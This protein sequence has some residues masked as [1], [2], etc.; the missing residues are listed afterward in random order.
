METDDAGEDFIRFSYADVMEP[1]AGAN[2]QLREANESVVR[3]Y[4]NRIKQFSFTVRVEEVLQELMQS[5]GGVKISTVAEHLGL[6]VR[7]LQRRLEG[8]GATFASLLE[9]H[10]RQMAHDALAHTEMSITEIAY[11][12][13][14]S[15]PS[16]FSRTCCRWFGVSP[17]AYRRRI[18]QLPS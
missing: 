12:I 6:S 3:Q 2:A 11:A 13:G 17:A 18:R 5:G 14:F 15:D 4:L 10:C 8:E 9:K 16:N 1:Y 7:T